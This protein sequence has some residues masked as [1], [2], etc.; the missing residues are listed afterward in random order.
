MKKSLA[1]TLLVLFTGVILTLVTEWVVS[2]RHQ[3]QSRA[4]MKQH[5]DA[6]QSNLQASIDRIIS[7]NRTLAKRLTDNPD[8]FDD[9]ESS[10][11]FEGINSQPPLISLALARDFKVVSVY[12]QR[13]NESA[14]GIDYRFRPEFMRA[15]RRAIASRDTV[16][17]SRVILLQTGR[18]GMI[19]RTPVFQHDSYLGLASTTVD[20]ALLLEQAQPHDGPMPTLL[21]QANNPHRGLHMVQGDSEKFRQLPTG[22][23]VQLPEDT[24]WEIRAQLPTVPQA[25]ARNLYDGIRLAGALLT[26]LLVLL[27]LK[28]SGVLDGLLFT[29]KNIT[30]R[31]SLLLLT[32]LPILLLTL[33]VELTYYKTMQHSTAQ[34]MQS[35]TNA[36]SRQILART[37]A[38]FDIPRQAMFG[39]ELFRS[40]MLNTDAPD[41]VLSF[42]VSQLRI[43]PQLTF[44]SIANLQGEYFAASRPP[45]GLDRT[46]RMQWT[47][48][49]SDR[50]MRVH[51]A[52]DSN[53]P[54]TAYVTGNHFF[55]ARTTKWYQQAMEQQRLLW[56]PPY[57]YNTQDTEKQYQGLG[58]GI[59]AP[60]YDIHNQLTGVMTADV[61]L[62]QLSDFLKTQSQDLGSILFLVEQNGN[63]LASS[64]DEPLYTH[65]D[66]RENTTH[67]LQAA[68]AR[69]P[70]IRAAAQYIQQ[71]DNGSGAQFLAV[72]GQ[73]HLL[74][75]QQLDIPDG[76]SLLLAV[77]MPSDILSSMSGNIWRDALYIGWLSL[78]FSA[79][80]ILFVTHWLTRPLYG[81]EHWASQ[82][83]EGDLLAKMPA[84]GPTREVGSLSRSLDFMARQLHTH[85]QELEQRV[86]QRTDELRQ[87]N[88]QLER[89]SLTDSLTG[90]ANRRCLDEQSMRL[91]QK[92][93]RLRCPLSLLMLDVDWFKKYNDHYG[94][95]AG[96]QALVTLGSVLAHFARRPDDLAAR[97]GGEEF[98]LLLFN[99]PPEAARDIAEQLI[100]KVAET[101]MQH[102]LSPLGRI[103][104]SVGVATCIPLSECTIDDL[105]KRADTALYSA[106]NNGR[107]RLYLCAA[108]CADTAHHEAKPQ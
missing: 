105:F 89:L 52:N 23:F 22:S 67:R 32:L 48:F 84:P 107:N 44:L 12:P 63:L 30:L 25:H 50:E 86:S 11:L 21:V 14:L 49:A 38:F 81:L 92:A 94:H 96:D 70:A 79:T 8:A 27:M 87:A 20:I 56:Y 78:L 59:S 62:S 3:Q 54:S 65:D 28:R 4:E 57:A 10:G 19:V 82:L 31:A 75:W 99:T 101:N 100:S 66:T 106:K 46:I 37:Q 41:T 108:P 26:T 77:A 58:I 73:L 68:T 39:T 24:R 51:W 76:P 91:Q 9:P 40:G 36:L 43:Q 103:S 88:Q 2:Q 7:D 97:Y 85:T 5:L 33:I 55:D 42:F 45:A 64:T 104:I 90:L 98:A 60:L 102:S 71:D 95:Q 80:L 6:L 34:L 53:R 47:T 17:T 18:P 16:L 74:D 83:R 61:A 1:A 29:R 15:I 35:Q 69:H 93:Q 13:R 72:D